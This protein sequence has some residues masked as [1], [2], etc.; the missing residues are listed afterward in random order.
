MSKSAV[1][2]TIKLSDAQVS[3]LEC[4]DFDPC[5]RAAASVL[6]AW[7]TDRLT[8]YSDQCDLLFAALNEA[9]N[10]EDAF[11]EI[12]SH[13]ADSRRCAARAARS[14]CALASKVLRGSE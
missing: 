14:L 11:A 7:S 4:R 10:A 12:T 2:R 5:D 8:F 13:D 9:S 3:A 1:K 6:A